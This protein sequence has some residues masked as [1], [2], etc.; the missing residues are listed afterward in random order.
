MKF[1]SLVC[2]G[3]G[4]G[5]SF[6]FSG[7]AKAEE[8]VAKYTVQVGINQ[9]TNSTSKNATKSGGTSVG[10]GYGLSN[11]GS[12]QDGMTSVDLLYNNNSKSGNKLETTGI[13]YSERLLA[14]KGKSKSANQ[15]YYGASIGVV[16]SK[17]NYKTVFSVGNTATA[18]TTTSKSKSGVGFRLLAGSKTQSNLMLEL[19]YNIAP[20]VTV[21]GTKFDPNSVSLS[22]K[23][24]GF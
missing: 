12:K 19:A 13:Y 23:G 14:S 7:S 17:F 3:A 15:F 5:A 1:I 21:S 11:K 24:K 4:F 22:I 9:L 2:L 6:W 20:R 18:T 10:I 16:Q 8:P